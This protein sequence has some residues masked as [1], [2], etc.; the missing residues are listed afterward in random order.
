MQFMKWDSHHYTMMVATH[1]RPEADDWTYRNPLRGLT[2][3]D[4]PQPASS[5]L[6]SL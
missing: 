4:I 3:M 5:W 1:H 2:G 6:R